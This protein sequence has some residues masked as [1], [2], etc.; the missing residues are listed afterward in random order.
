MSSGYKCTKCGETAY[1][2]CVNQR[3]VFPEDQVATLIGNMITIDAKRTGSFDERYRR[4]EDSDN[5]TVTYTFTC[6]WAKGQNEI[7]AI[8][9]SG[10]EHWLIDTDKAILKHAICDHDWK[11]VSGECMFGCCKAEVKESV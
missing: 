8:K 1:S 10:I 6:K 7:E 2:K 4:A 3:S 5:W 11:I 9:D